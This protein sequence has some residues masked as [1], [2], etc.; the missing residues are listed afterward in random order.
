MGLNPGA[1]VLNNATGSVY[2]SEDGQ[3]KFGVGGNFTSYTA[4]VKD[5]KNEAVI[6]NAWLSLG[7]NTVTAYCR[8]AV[9]NE[10]TTTL[11]LVKE[12]LPPSM[13]SS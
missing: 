8:D 10:S 12:A 3:F 1:V 5:V 11:N 6:Q 2:C 13:S 9:G 4:S 7:D